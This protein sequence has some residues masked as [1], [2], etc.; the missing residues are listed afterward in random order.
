M[1]R[2]ESIASRLGMVAVG[3][4]TTEPEPEDVKKAPRKRVQHKEDPR[5]TKLK[6]LPA[7]DLLTAIV[8]KSKGFNVTDAN[9]ERL[10]A[11]HESQPSVEVVYK[12]L[13]HN[14]S[15]SVVAAFKSVLDSSD[16]GWERKGVILA[17]EKAVF[18]AV[19]EP[20]KVVSAL[21]ERLYYIERMEAQ[22]RDKDDEEADA[23]VE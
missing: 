23:E 5:L 6:T 19:Q 12:D 1:A 16:P 15:R 11:D 4:K 3:K 20:E 21:A 7:Q 22:K 13:E 10:L 14:S 9:L 2:L 8:K 18:F 17:T